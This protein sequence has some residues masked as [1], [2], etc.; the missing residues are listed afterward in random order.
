MSLGET[1][2][3]EPQLGETLLGETLLGE[4]SLWENTLYRFNS[5]SFLLGHFDQFLRGMTVQPKQ[6]VDPNVVEDV[7]T[8]LKYLWCT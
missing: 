3:G 7:S 8:T 5:W 4:T 6:Q 2:L 1:L